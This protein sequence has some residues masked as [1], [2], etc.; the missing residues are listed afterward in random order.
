[1][2]RR[3]RDRRARAARFRITLLTMRLIRRAR[4]LDRERADGA[5]PR[6]DP[7][8][9]PARRL[10]RRTRP[11]LL[12]YRAGRAPAIDA[13]PPY[14]LPDLAIEIRSPSTWRYDIGTKKSVYER[15]GLP[16][17]WLVDGDAASLL[18]FRRSTPRAATFDVALEFDRTR[19]AHVAA[20]AGLRAR[21]RR[22]V[23]LRLSG[24]AAAR[25]DAVGVEHRVDVAQAADR[26]L[27]DLQV[28]D[29]DDEPVLRPSGARRRS[30]PRRC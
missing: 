3:R 15:D 24:S 27:E 14:P 19:D 5:R 2:A 1:M 7:A 26:G 11:D 16:E 10:Q 21:R 13:D 18:V 22:A 23:R 17:L 6:D 28:A 4:R 8:R 20:A 12:W 29:L 25:R 9:R 30:A